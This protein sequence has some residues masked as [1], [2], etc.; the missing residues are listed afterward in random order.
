MKT[1]GKLIYAALLIVILSSSFACDNNDGY[2][3]NDF[4][5]SIAT[6]VPKGGQSYSL[7]LDNGQKL[8]P[9][10]ADIYYSPQ[11]NQ[12]V[13]V[14]Y[15]ILSDKMDGY[16]HYIKVNDI[17]DIV[18]KPIIELTEENAD[19][20]GN[21]EVIVN[22]FWIANHYLNANFSFN[23]GGVRPH[24]INMV[25]NLQYVNE[26]DHI[27][28]LEFRHNSYNSHSDRLFNGF[29]SF[30]L[31]PFREEERDSIPINIKVKDW[32]GEKEYKLMYRYNEMS[33]DK[34]EAAIPNITSSEYR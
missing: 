1:K 17:W 25:Q 13:F 34:T 5:I 15:T 14:N 28:E 16:D 6:V 8:W 12:R 22:E 27:L 7:L 18:T 3:L 26:D 24:A 30:D 9:A 20:I 31:K 32:E 4:R 2:S 21:D 33:N 19:S 23:Y 10:A 11:E 29:V